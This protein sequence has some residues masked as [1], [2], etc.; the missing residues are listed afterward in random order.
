MCVNWPYLGGMVD[1]SGTFGRD[2]RA[3]YIRALAYK[4]GIERRIDFLRQPCGTLEKM[5]LG[6]LQRFLFHEE[7]DIFRGN[8]IFRVK[9]CVVHEFK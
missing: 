7:K 5:A 4:G 9:L 2:L 8:I 6:V 3:V 1:L